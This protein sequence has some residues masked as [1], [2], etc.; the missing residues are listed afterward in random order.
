MDW[1]SV[2]QLI[3]DVALT[4]SVIYLGLLTQRLQAGTLDCHK[5]APCVKAVCL[6][7]DDNMETRQE[8]E[9]S[10]L[11]ELPGGEESFTF[12]PM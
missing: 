11:R 12:K 4:L 8:V 7:L 2:L 3:W 9:P 10:P 5:P 1:M 6:E